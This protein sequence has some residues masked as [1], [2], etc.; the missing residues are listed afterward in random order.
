MASD[1]EYAKR[2]AAEQDAKYAARYAAES[3]ASQKE[4]Y[5]DPIPSLPWGD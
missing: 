1:E 3:G 2:Y 4:V 5:D